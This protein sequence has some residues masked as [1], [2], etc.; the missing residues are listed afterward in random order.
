MCGAAGRSFTRLQDRPEHVECLN[1]ETGQDAVCVHQRRDATSVWHV[2]GVWGRVRT[3]LEETSQSGRGVPPAHK[4]LLCPRC[5]NHSHRTPGARNSK[6]NWWHYGRKSNLFNCTIREYSNKIVKS[7]AVQEIS[8]IH[9]YIH[10]YIYIIHTYT[11][12][13]TYIYTYI[14]MYIYKWRVAHIYTLCG[15]SVL[16]INT[17]CKR[18]LEPVLSRWCAIP[19]NL[20]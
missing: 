14:D 4:Q 12:I 7:R 11:Y 13:H 19:T 16:T 3:T 20:H 9:S 17:R 15:L 10:T 1:G 6:I 18:R 8:D 5:R 2:C